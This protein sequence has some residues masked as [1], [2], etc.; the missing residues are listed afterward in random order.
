M[1]ASIVSAFTVNEPAWWDEN[2]EHDHD[3]YPASIAE[4]RA[5]AG[6][7]WEPVE[8][9]GYQR[10]VLSA[11]QSSG[12]AFDDHDEVVD[13]GD[14]KRAIYRPIPN[15]KRV[16]R[17]DTQQH[18]ATM[19]NSW[20]LIGMG[21]MWGIIEAVVAG[22]SNLQCETGGVINDSKQAWALARLDEPWSPPGD[23]SL[24]YPYIAFLNAFDGSAA[25]KAVNTS[26]RVVCANTY[27]M[28]DAEGARSGRQ[29]TF[30]HTKNVHNRIE[31]AKLALKGFR[32]DT[33]DWIELAEQL[34]LLKVTPE[35]TE[36]YVREFIPSPP[37][38]IVS[39]RVV[40]NVEEARQAIRNILA[41]KTCEGI[42]GSAWGLVQASGE[43]L[44]HVRTSRSWETKLRRTILTPE[45]LKAK[46]VSLALSVA[47]A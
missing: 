30:R 10:I 25:A 9:P 44:D 43:Y 4:A 15:E 16:I 18:L 29:F 33:Q 5:W 8:V 47:K 12:F 45:S 27:G 31:Q 19:H 40:K 6:Q 32:K 36:L 22:E 17:S 26:V 35:R 28:A 7:E 37:D 13:L 14:G 20:E 46:A 42:R 2:G 11:D 24:I 34:A 23:P 39:D 3:R 41:S 1:P 38:G 21:E